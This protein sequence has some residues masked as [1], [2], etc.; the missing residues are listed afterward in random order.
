MIEDDDAR[1]RPRTHEVGMP[2]ESMSE[3]E[4]LYRIGMLRDEIVRL[5]QAVEAR[6]RSKSAAD[7]VFKL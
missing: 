7:S 3:D 6:R 2:I 5:E 1:K 4:L